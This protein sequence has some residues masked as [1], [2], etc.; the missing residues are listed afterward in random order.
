MQVDC[1]TFTNLL[2]IC[3]HG[4]KVDDGVATPLALIPTLHQIDLPVI[5]ATNIISLSLGSV[6]RRQ[7]QHKRAK[8]L[9][10]SF[11]ALPDSNWFEINLWLRR[12]GG[13]ARGQKL[14]ET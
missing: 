2:A 3:I 6:V 13:T 12:K 14:N 8:L 11:I 5:A 10:D 1:I 9:Q 4:D 7:D